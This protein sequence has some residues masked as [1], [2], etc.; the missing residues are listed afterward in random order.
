MT[1]KERQIKEENEDICPLKLF[2]LE[3]FHFHMESLTQD[4]SF[5]SGKLSIEQFNNEKKHFVLNLT[6]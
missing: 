2:R 4:S 6:N 3:N 5:Y 1:E